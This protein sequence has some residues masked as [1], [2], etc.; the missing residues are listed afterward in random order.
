MDCIGTGNTKLNRSQET[1]TR[2]CAFSFNEYF[3]FGSDETKHFLLDPTAC[4]CKHVRITELVF[5]ASLGPI[6]LEFYANTLASSDGA[7]YNMFNRNF[8]SLSTADTILRL[9]PTISDN[10][11][12]QAGRCV[13]ATGANPITGIPSIDSEKKYLILNKAIKYLITAHNTN[14]AGA[15]MQI[16]FSIC[17]E[18]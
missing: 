16:D 11:I 13:V 1:I 10:G 2:G 8:N 3:T 9:N 14:G 4:A 15:R 12:R 17:E 7:V 5:A 18:S 6:D